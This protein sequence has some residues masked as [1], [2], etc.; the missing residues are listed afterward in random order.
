MLDPVALQR[1]RAGFEGAFPP[2]RILEYCWGGLQKI[3]RP[4]LADPEIPGGLGE[5]GRCEISR[6][7]I[8]TKAGRGHRQSPSPNPGILYVHK[9]PTI[10]RKTSTIIARKN[11]ET[12][13]ADFVIDKFQ[14]RRF[15]SLA[16]RPPSASDSCS[17]PSWQRKARPISLLT[18]WISEG[19]TQA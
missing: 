12:G 5:A 4:P 18:L 2:G 6:S 1:R 3:D 15:T 17:C 14:I 7:A 11:G 8:E 19:L 9:I 16:G 13:N 10:L